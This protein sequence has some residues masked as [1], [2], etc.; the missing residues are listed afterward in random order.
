MLLIVGAWGKS[1]GIL[2]HDVSKIF[3]DLFRVRS[4]SDHDALPPVFS[5][6]SRTSNLQT[7]TVRPK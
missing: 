7:V 4:K 3:F 2:L 6:L 1:W 5:R